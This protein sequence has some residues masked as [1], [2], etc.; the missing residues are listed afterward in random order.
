MT[1]DDPKYGAL[2]GWGV[3]VKVRDDDDERE[4]ATTVGCTADAIW[5]AT[6]QLADYSVE[7]WGLFSLETQPTQP[8]PSLQPQRR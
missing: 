2:A 7:D 5:C 8:R 6:L 1:S 4:T 3:A